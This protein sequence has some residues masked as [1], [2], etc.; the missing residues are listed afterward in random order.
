MNAEIH[1]LLDNK[2][3]ELEESLM[4]HLTARRDVKG[5]ELLADLFENQRVALTIEMD[6]IADTLQETKQ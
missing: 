5:I 1:A 2:S 3:T 6:E 4:Q